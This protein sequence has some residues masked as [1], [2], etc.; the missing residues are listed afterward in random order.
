MEKQSTDRVIGIEDY[1]DYGEI[2]DFGAEYFQGAT[3]TQDSDSRIVQVDCQRTP[4]SMPTVFASGKLLQAVDAHRAVDDPECIAMSSAVEGLRSL[5]QAWS[6]LADAFMLRSAQIES[7]QAAKKT[8]KEV[9]VSQKLKGLLDSCK[10]VQAAFSGNEH[11]TGFEACIAKAES[12]LADADSMDLKQAKREVKKAFE[13]IAKT[14]V[15][16][17]TSLMAALKERKKLLLAHLQADIVKGKQEASNK[18]VSDDMDE[19]CEKQ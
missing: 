11:F 16:L 18:M 14:V 4:E 9:L 6:A 19:I 15:A 7:R 13:R 1:E 12:T 8:G 10:S 2:G 17:Q 5:K 3:L